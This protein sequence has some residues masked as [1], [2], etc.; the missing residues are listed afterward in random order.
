M[1][2]TGEHMLQCT[3][4]IPE[5]IPPLFVSGEVRRNIFLLVKESLHNIVKH[6]NATEVHIDFRIGNYLCVTVC[7]NG[8]GIKASESG[9]RDEGN[10]L[11]NM[12][13]RVESM[14]G[15]FVVLNRDGLTIKAE[16]PLDLSK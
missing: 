15:K 9:K 8:A 1:E 4:F 13:K 2:Y 10:G 11:R 14:R 7:D 6:A 16:V 3:V 12:R 5:L